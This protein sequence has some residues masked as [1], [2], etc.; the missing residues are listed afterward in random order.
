[1]AKAAPLIPHGPKEAALLGAVDDVYA[2]RMDFYKLVSASTKRTPA[3]EKSQ[4]NRIIRGHIGD[5]TG[6]RIKL[7]AKLLK[8]ESSEFLRAAEEHE[9]AEGTP[10]SRSLTLRGLSDELADLTL[11]VNR[12]ADL[13]NRLVAQGQPGSQAEETR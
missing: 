9:A 10:R 12:L 4:F 13:V 11:R 6:W 3:N 7:Y 2:N 8:R 1:V 5:Q